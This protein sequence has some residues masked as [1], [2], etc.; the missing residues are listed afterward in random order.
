[1]PYFITGLGIVVLSTMAGLM[2]PEAVYHITF[3][4]LGSEIGITGLAAGILFLAWS[5]KKA[6]M[7]VRR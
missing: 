5:Y 3:P 2:P 4:E 1:M 7:L 6:S